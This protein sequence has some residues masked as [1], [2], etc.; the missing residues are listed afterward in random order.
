LAVI[1]SLRDGTVGFTK[2]ERFLAELCE[3]TFLSLWSHPN[4]FRARNR[5][6]TDLAVI[7][8]QDVV[9]FSDK[10]CECKDGKHGWSRWYRRAILESAHQLHRAAAWINAHPTE[11]YMDVRCERRFPFT[12]PANPIV[13]LVAV[14][15]GARDAAI[16]HGQ[17]DG[18]AFVSDT[19]GSEPFVVGDLDRT[20]D[21]VHIFDDVSLSVVLSE[22]D[23]VAD[24]VSYLSK[25]AAFLRGRV[26][27]A[28]SELAL[29]AYY[30]RT[31]G[32]AAAHDFAMTKDGEAATH[33]LVDGN[34]AEFLASDVYKRKREAD[35]PSYA[36]DRMIA[37]IAGH[38]DRGTL[39][40]GQER[41]LD[42]IEADLRVLAS[43]NRFSRRWLSTM[44]LDMRRMSA[45]EPEN[46][47]A[48]TVISRLHPERGYVFLSV[49]R[50]GLE[51][52]RRSR[53]TI[54]AAHTEFAKLR[55]EDFRE[56]VGIGVAPDGDPDDSVDMVTR[57]F[58]KWTDE[59]RVRAEEMLAKTNWSRDTADLE[60]RWRAVEYPQ[61]TPR[62]I[63]KQ[64]LQRH[65]AKATAKA[66]RRAQRAAR[67]RNRR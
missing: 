20:K 21:F 58:D 42:G 50:D 25:R 14:A 61:P 35:T 18:L 6:L 5:E 9:L 48:R 64:T 54:V 56:I 11:I 40:S 60:T 26:V 43:E 31:M 12:L 10:S 2:S 38:A 37:S 52:Y 30:L 44:L 7:F 15:T 66:K 19:D 53:R 65:D 16:R 13:H 62:T 63:A 34:W 32:D 45:H 55:R 22:R 49:K 23:T 36:W 39:V 59:D 51:D 33:V 46:V 4:L 29:L 17:G 8:G 3:R 24:F 57:V 27:G 41:G 1:P 47:R 67:K 28:D